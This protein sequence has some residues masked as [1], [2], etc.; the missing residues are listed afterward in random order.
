MKDKSRAGAKKARPTDRLFAAKPCVFVHRVKRGAPRCE[1]ERGE[2]HRVCASASGATNS[3]CVPDSL[4]L[5][6]FFLA[7]AFLLFFFSTFFSHFLFALFFLI[8][9]LL[10]SIF[11][12]QDALCLPTYIS[13]QP[14]SHTFFT[15]VPTF[16]RY[17]VCHHGTTSYSNPTTASPSSS[18][19]SE[20][21]SLLSSQLVHNAGTS[22]QERTLFQVLFPLSSMSRPPERNH[23]PQH[24]QSASSSDRGIGTRDRERDVHPTRRFRK[25]AG[26]SSLRHR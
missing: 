20:S 3:C 23:P 11:L 5:Y 1:T 24:Q 18:R 10:L 17:C 13:T 25:Q 7:V 19:S 2:D 9:H 22:H 15:T 14:S 16:F 6:L 12:L 26:P 4:L 21:D 8:P